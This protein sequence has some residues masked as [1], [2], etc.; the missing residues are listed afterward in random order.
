MAG[1]SPAQRAVKP[2]AAGAVRRLP[3]APVSLLCAGCWPTSR[4]TEAF[5]RCCSTPS[6]SAGSM[7]R[8][9]P[10]LKARRRH[11]EELSRSSSWSR[12]SSRE[13][14][15]ATQSTRRR[16]RDQPRRRGGLP[17]PSA[18]GRGRAGL[19]ADARP[20]ARL[21]QRA[22]PA[23]D[24]EVEPRL[25][26]AHELDIDRRAAAIEER[27]VLL[28]FRQVDA[29]TLAQGIEAARRARVPAPGER[30]RV[31]DAVPPATAAT[32]GQARH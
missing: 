14:R 18:V 23:I 25:M 2:V 3:D 26:A 24:D 7:P 19:V 6:I 20:P 4:A 5:R 10:A 8:T 29:I 31:D 22:L 11:G 16:P 28:P 13:K 32:P 21:Q 27:T 9:S 1:C 30:Q 17:P 12:L 15:S